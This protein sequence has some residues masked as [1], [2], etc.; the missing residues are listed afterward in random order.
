MADVLREEIR[1]G[2]VLITLNRPDKLNALSWDL[3][4]ELHATLDEIG[5]D[6]SLRVVV[7][8]GAG[9]GFCAGLDLSERS[10]S[11]L[12]KGLSGPAGGM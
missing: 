3:V 5:R 7:L 9:R 4:D 11:S 12:S 1:P 10:G 2:V 6:N 8:T